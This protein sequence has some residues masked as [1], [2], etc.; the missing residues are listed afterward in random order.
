LQLREMLAPASNQ[1]AEV[2]AQDVDEDR[3]RIVGAERHRRWIVHRDHLGVDAHA[4][5][6]FGDDLLRLLLLLGIDPLTRGPVDR[7]RR[8][9]A[10]GTIT[11]RCASTEPVLAAVPVSAASP[12]S[13]A[14]GAAFPARARLGLRGLALGG[15]ADKGFGVLRRSLFR[16]DLD[17]DLVSTQ[18]Q[19]IERE[20][21]SL[22]DGHCLDLYTRSL[23][24]VVSPWLTRISP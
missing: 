15:D 20:A 14:A 4:G 5:K 23:G 19:L 13:G 7:W 9:P 16:E 3:R 22:I 1:H 24:H 10:G 2:T 11:G 21:N 12:A 17:I 8:S 6:Q 18:A